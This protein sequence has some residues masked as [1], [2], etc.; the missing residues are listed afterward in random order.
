MLANQDGI[1][2]FFHQLLAGLG[3]RIGAGIEGPQAGGQWPGHESGRSVR[4]KSRGMH[5]RKDAPCVG[6]SIRFAK[7][8]SGC[9]AACCLAAWWRSGGSRHGRSGVTSRLSV[10]PG[11]LRGVSDEQVRAAGAGE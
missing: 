10:T 7:L 6:P 1:E 2:A 4:P 3:N 8:A 5:R 11:P 9:D